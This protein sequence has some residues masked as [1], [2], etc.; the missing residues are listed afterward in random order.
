M[1]RESDS[2]AV[3][4]GNSAVWSTYMPIMKFQAKLGIS[5]NCS[6]VLVL[7]GTGFWQAKCLDLANIELLIDTP[8]TLHWP[9]HLVRL[10]EAGHDPDFECGHDWSVIWWHLT[11]VGSGV[12]DL[13]WQSDRGRR[14]SST[15]G[16]SRCARSAATI[17]SAALATAICRFEP[18]GQVCQPA[19]DGHGYASSAHEASRA[20]YR[21]ELYGFG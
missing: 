20:V 15:W 17:R 3:R 8:K 14:I 9:D 21:R 2:A 6:V 1:R 5:W 13:Q 19:I 11:S 18:A 7:P 4:Q 16:C 12:V 10:R